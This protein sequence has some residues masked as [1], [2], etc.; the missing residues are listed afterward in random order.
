[1]KF[2]PLD[3]SVPLGMNVMLIIANVINLVYNIPQMVKTYQTK[4][5]RDF[6]GW[7][8]SLRIVGNAIW[9]VYSIYVANLLMLIN[10]VVTVIASVFVA[11]YKVKE[12]IA[13]RKV[14][15]VADDDATPMIEFREV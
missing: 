14:T 12:M 15:A 10:N 8:L 6:S 4:S 5:T 9:V 11:Y 1:M 3:P 2:E 7:F 13:E